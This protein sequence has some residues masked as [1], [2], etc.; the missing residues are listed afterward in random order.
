VA[1]ETSEVLG[2][3]NLWTADTPMSQ[4]RLRTHGHR[5]IL[6]LTEVN[7]PV[8]IWGFNMSNRRSLGERPNEGE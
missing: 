5:T 1:L 7:I 3:S 2:Q 8:K 6:P 4:G